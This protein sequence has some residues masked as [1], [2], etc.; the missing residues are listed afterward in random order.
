MSYCVELTP[1]AERQLA[2]LPATTQAAI[3]R[4]LD[5]LETDPRPPGFAPLKAQ[6]RG[7]Y[8]VRVGQY[9]V[10]YQISD[11]PPVVTVWQIGHR[12]KFYDKATR[13]LR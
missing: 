12:A 2:S 9:R 1:T 10:A 13:R 7:S 5:A 3:A 6:L 8:R 4:Q 11:D